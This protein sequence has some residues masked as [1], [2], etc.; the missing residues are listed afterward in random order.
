MPIIEPRNGH[1]SSEASAERVESLR[2]FDVEVENGSIEFVVLQVL[3][4][5]SME[6][7]GPAFGRKGDIP[8]L[9]KFRVVVERGDL[10]F[11]DSLR[12]RVGIGS[13]SAVKKR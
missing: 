4:K 2:R 9:G 6:H 7:I 13:R 10:E 5:A 8:D 11:G 1:R 3:E 12:G